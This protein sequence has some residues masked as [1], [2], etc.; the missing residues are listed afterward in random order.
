MKTFKVSYFT[1]GCK[2][3]LYLHQFSSGLDVARFMFSSY[4]VGFFT[5]KRIK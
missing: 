1:Q 2:V 3:E 4:K 5:I